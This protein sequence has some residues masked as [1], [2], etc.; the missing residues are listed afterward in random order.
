[1]L[2]GLVPGTNPPRDFVVLFGLYVGPS[3]PIGGVLSEMESLG[4]RQSKEGMILL[5]SRHGIL[6]FVL[7]RNRFFACIGCL[8]T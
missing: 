1:M 4:S 3:R 8:S 7:G 6:W 5:L 2:D